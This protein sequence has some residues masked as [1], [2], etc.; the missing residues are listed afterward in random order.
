MASI[1]LPTHEWTESC[2]R[3]AEQTTQADEL[4]VCVD[5]ATDPAARA[6]EERPDCTVVV[7]GDPEGCSGKANAV[8]AGLEAAE[9]NVVVLTDDDVPRDEG[10]L[11]RVK[12]GVERHGAVSGAPLYVHEGGTGRPLGAALEV[13]QGTLALALAFGDGVWGGA[14]GFDRAHLD[15]EAALVHDLRRTVTDDL[16]VGEHLGGAETAD[17]GLFAPVPVET[18]LS[19]VLGRYVR[20]SRSFEYAEGASNAPVYVLG[21]LQALVLAVGTLPAAV[22]MG[23][24]GVAVLGLYGVP[25]RR[26]WS[27]LFAPVSFLVHAAVTAVTVRRETF[28]WGGRRYRW[29]S[30][31]EVKVLD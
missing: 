15:D 29:R 16:L 8:A 10:W 11:S 20:F 4:L 12:A 5:H 17:R 2:E 23:L 7:V 1:L 19:G 27:A 14:T 30:K 13:A 22:A 31:F 25:W 9:Q 6:A 18:S 21:V 28:E 26:R 24:G 3:L